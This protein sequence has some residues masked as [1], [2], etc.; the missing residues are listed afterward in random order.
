M[1]KA[2]KE[3]QKDFHFC[4]CSSNRCNAFCGSSA[5]PVQLAYFNIPRLSIYQKGAV[6]GASKFWISR[7]LILCSYI[8]LCIGVLERQQYFVHRGYLYLVFCFYFC[9]FWLQSVAGE[10]RAF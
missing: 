7:I 3:R 10:T 9:C 2:G 1:N 8:Y 4:D 6:L 5:L